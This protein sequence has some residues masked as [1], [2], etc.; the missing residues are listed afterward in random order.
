M[1]KLEGKKAK[2]KIVKVDK[3]DKKDEKNLR[4]LC[5]CAASG[6]CASKFDAKMRLGKSSVDVSIKDRDKKIS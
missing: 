1:A 3:G 4:N 5:K 2:L 6:D